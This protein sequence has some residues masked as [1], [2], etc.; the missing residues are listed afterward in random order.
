MRFPGFTDEWNSLS[1]DEIFEIRNGYTPSKANPQYWNNGTIPWFRMEDIRENGGILK[2]AIQHITQDAVK[3]TGTFA[4]YSIILA[5]T[6][7]I[8]VH[9]MLI[10]DSLANQRFTNFSVRKSLSH[11]YNP[12]FG[13]YSFFKIDK[14]SK[15]NTNSGGLLSVDIPG[16]KRLSFSMPS[17]EEQTRIADFLQLIDERI[18]TQRRLIED[19]EK[20]KSAIIDRCYRGNNNIRLGKFISQ[21]SHRNRSNHTYRVMSVSN[22]RGFVLQSEQFADREIASENTTSYKI[23]T[24]DIF[25]YNPARIN[26]G[27]IARFKE[28]DKGIVSPMYVCF[29]IEGE[30]HP[31]YLEYFFQT[32]RFKNDVEL[33]LEGSVRLC[34]NFDALCEIK[35]PMLALAEQ[36]AISSTLE[37]LDNKIDLEQ[38]VLSNM[39]KQRK[40]LLSK[41]FI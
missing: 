14:W 17:L 22:V 28:H 2:D 16:L 23:V 41:L 29:K 10:A 21:V 18:A 36:T 11:M 15:Q 1:I 33:R 32:Q 5:T 26:I 3:K 31:Q 19:L 30:L 25:A 27:S 13:Y 24:R 9:A 20:L 35:I 6:A 38:K 37:T 34:L 39:N 12:Y 8:G 4:P 40:Y 7:T